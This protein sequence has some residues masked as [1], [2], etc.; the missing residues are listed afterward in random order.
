MIKKLSIIIPVYNE[1][2]TIYKLLDIVNGVEL[3]NGV[4]KELIVIDD[5]SSDNSKTEIERYISE[6]SVSN[7]LVLSHSQNQGKGGSVQTGIKEATGDYVIIQDA[8]L[9]LK[10]EEINLLLEPIV[11]GEADVVF[12]SRFLNKK[13]HEKEAFSHHLANKFF[14]WLANI[15]NRTKLTDMQ[16]CYKVL[17]APIFKQLKLREKRFA[18]DPEITARL[19]KYKELRW[20]EVPITYIPRT[21]NEGKKIG[22]MDGFRQ[23]YS[24]VKYGLFSKK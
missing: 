14:T 23:I 1:E 2:S 6:T 11:K 9:E 12:G 8:D 24:I 7:I 17:P 13:R 18:F 21:Q 16:T 3:I 15:I 5:C 20:T 22:Y 4:E 10:P 19:A